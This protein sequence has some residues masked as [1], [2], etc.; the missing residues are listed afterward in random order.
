MGELVKKQKIT[1][2]ILIFFLI[3]ILIAGLSVNFPATA[4]AQTFIFKIPSGFSLSSV[5][6][7]EVDSSGN[8]YAVLSGNVIKFSSDG[9]VLLEFGSSGS[10]DGQFYFPGA[11]VLF[12]F[13]AVVFAE[14]AFE[15]ATSMGSDIFFISILYII[16]RA[17]KGK[18]SFRG[19]FSALQY[20]Y[21]P[22]LI[23]IAMISLTPEIDV[24]NISENISPLLGAV[25]GIAIPLILWGLILAILAVREAHGFGTGK[26]IGTIII[27]L[28]ITIIIFAV[29]II[30]VLSTFLGLDLFNV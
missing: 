8:I 11:T 2:F 22:A 1:S 13:S 5:K 3:V 26:A 30:A 4:N 12:F 20:A 23:A 27:S 21:I 7:L 19:I 16:G 15:G 10:G 14:G 28:I 17:L 25:I 29:V 9:K 18:A 24:K 6:D